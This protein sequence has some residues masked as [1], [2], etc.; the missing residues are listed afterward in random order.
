[1][2]NTKGIFKGAGVVDWVMYERS[3]FMYEKYEE[4]SYTWERDGANETEN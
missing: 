3:E 1:M 2:I 4:S